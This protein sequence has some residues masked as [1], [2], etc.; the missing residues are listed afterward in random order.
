MKQRR[1][2]AA[3]ALVPVVLWA[4]LLWA[5]PASAAEYCVTCSG[6]DAQ[7]RCSF[8]G[9]TSAE[10]DPG[11]QLYCISTLARDGGHESC[12]IA[13]KIT[14]PC[15]GT[16]K[17][18]ALP[19][20]YQ[21]MQLPAKIDAEPHSLPETETASPGEQEPVP[22]PIPASPP[23]VEKAEPAPATDADV[24]AQPMAKPEPGAKPVWNDK[25]GPPQAAPKTV[26]EMIKKGNED[27][28]KSLEKTGEAVGDAAKATGSVIEKAGSAVGD[29]AK[30][31]WKCLT[32]LFGDC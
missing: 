13:R 4:T 21:P 15:P 27:T 20:G 10:R 5:T 23:Q 28:S 7:Y 9:D 16:S 1:Q 24:E 26:E 17:V 19:D 30:K 2:R 14:S 32:T 3:A 22:A 25:S 11:L 8:D 12:S 6:P 29:A 18:L 31:T